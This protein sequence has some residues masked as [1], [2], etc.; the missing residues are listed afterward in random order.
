MYIYC[1]ASTFDLT[2]MPPSFMYKANCVTVFWFGFSP[3]LTSPQ[4]FTEKQNKNTKNGSQN[5]TVNSLSSVFCGR[6]NQCYPMWPDN[7]FH[8]IPNLW[9]FFLNVFS[10]K[11][12]T[13]SVF[14]DDAASVNR[15]LIFNR[16]ILRL[17]ITECHRR[18]IS[19]SGL[20]FL[21]EFYIQ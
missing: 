15:L 16:G 19:D 9:G 7:S 8:V 13:L 11:T 12:W 3:H 5:V 20:V 2:L 1:S 4:K 6:I 21:M 14:K 17:L 10:P 18:L